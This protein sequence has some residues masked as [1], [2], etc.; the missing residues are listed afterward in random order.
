MSWATS[1]DQF[2][3]DGFLYSSFKPPVFST[4]KFKSLQLPSGLLEVKK[5]LGAYH[6]APRI[7]L[8]W[9]TENPSSSFIS[10]AW[11]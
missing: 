11:N 7:T 5:I 8:T 1:S 6:T 2:D 4:R 9:M 3:R 10:L